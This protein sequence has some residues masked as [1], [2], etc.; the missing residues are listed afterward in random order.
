LQTFAMYAGLS[1][2]F[3]YLIL[4]LQQVAGY[5]ALEAGF[6]T[7]P[8]TF[9]LFLLSKRAGALADH[10]GARWFMGGGGLLA[11]SGL[12]LLLRVDAEADYV[13]QLLP[14]LLVFSG[15]LAATVAPL[16]ATVLADADEEHA[17]IASGTN[18]AIARAAGLLGVAALGAVIAAQ[19]T[20]SLDDRLAGVPLT[21]TGQAAVAE[22]KSRTLARADVSG[23]P[24]R[25]AVQIARAT[26]KAA[27]S[28][29]HTGMGISA[30]LVGLG[31]ILSLALV[32]A[33]RREVSC[34][35]CAGGQ[36]VAAPAGAVRERSPVAVP[37]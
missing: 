16:T 20:G 14:A 12:L 5:N 8:T 26:E 21:P 28:A 17:G 7:L 10:Y 34:A 4:F 25:E 19:F 37:A 29:F 13:T 36:L 1:V 33:P 9:V 18:N 3:F 24:P 27:V 23:L 32:R 35:D 31:G 22:A 30:A 15:G 2:L 6:A 11:A